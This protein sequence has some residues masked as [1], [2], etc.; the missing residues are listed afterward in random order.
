MIDREPPED[1][2]PEE[3]PPTDLA[4]RVEEYLAT[5]GTHA[6]GRPPGFWQ[7]LIAEYFEQE[8]ERRE[9]RRMRAEWFD[10]RRGRVRWSKHRG[11]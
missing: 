11:R 3:M 9:M 8:R 10:V 1:E 7:E 5:V 2:W 6:T 4:P